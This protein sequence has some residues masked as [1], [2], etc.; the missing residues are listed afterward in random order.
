MGVQGLGKKSSLGGQASEAEG[1]ASRLIHDPAGGVRQKQR[2]EKR[3]VLGKGGI[4][5]L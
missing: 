3:V 5:N 2:K 1:E 4:P